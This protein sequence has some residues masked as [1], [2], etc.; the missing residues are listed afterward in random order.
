MNI[1]DGAYIASPVDKLVALLS[2]GQK[3]DYSTFVISKN[4]L[5]G[6]GYR[7]SSGTGD[8]EGI[9]FSITTTNATNAT[10]TACHPCN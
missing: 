6:G 10:T 2:L 5:S 9:R 4:P 3:V 8:S 1:S 7:P